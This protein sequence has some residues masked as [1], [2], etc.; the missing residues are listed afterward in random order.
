M[1]SKTMN[2][3]N[4][5]IL[6][7]IWDTSCQENSEDLRKHAYVGTDVIILAFSVNGYIE[8]IEHI[9]MKEIERNFPGGQCPPIIL[10]GTMVDLRGEERHC[11][12]ADLSQA[13]KMV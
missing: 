8:N 6:V 10:V 3:D 9:W 1:D 5:V 13:T 11:T 7:N 12:G 2:I 4:E